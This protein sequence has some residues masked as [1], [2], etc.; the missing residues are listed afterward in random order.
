MGYTL[1]GRTL[2]AAAI[3][4]ALTA[5]GGGGGD[6]SPSNGGGTVS[7]VATVSVSGVASKG[8]LAYAKVT[9]YAVKSDGTAD[10]ANVLGSAITDA[11]GAYTISGLAPSVPVVLKVTPLPA[12]GGRP[13]TSMRDEVTHQALSVPVDS[14]FELSAVTVLNASGSTS[15]QITPF[16]HMAAKLA[17]TQ[18][19]A[20]TG[21]V[22]IGDVIRAANNSVS[23]ALNIPILTE[24]PTFNANGTPTNAA[25][26][27]LA[28]VA[29]LARNDGTCG[30]EA[31]DLDK[32]KCAVNKLRDAVPDTA[33]AT[34][35]ALLAAPLVSALNTAQ[36][37]AANDAG[38]TNVADVSTGV[39]TAPV[40][41]SAQADAISRAKA[42]FQNIR[43]ALYGLGNQNDSQSLAARA[44]V[45]GNA[46]DAV[47][48]PAN[49]EGAMSVF[50]VLEG[51]DRAPQGTLSTTEWFDNTTDMVPGLYGGGCKVFP[52]DTFTAN[53]ATDGDMRSANYVGCRLL[54]GVEVRWDQP[55]QGGFNAT[56]QQY[57]IKVSRG[58]T[59]LNQ[60]ES[61]TY[62]VQTVLTTQVGVYNGQV[63]TPADSQPVVIP[64]LS[65][66][67][68]TVSRVSRGVDPQDASRQAYNDLTMTGSIAPSWKQVFWGRVQSTPIVVGSTTVSLSVGS[69]IVHVPTNLIQLNLNGGFQ[70]KTAA[71][72][73]LSSMA[74]KSGSYAKTRTGLN[75]YVNAPL[76][77]P[78]SV[79]H[80]EF[81]SSV[82]G[83]AVASGT[84]EVDQFVDMGLLG[85]DKRA[86]PNHGVFTGSLKESAQAA[87]LFSGTIAYTQWHSNG[88][89]AP[90]N[91][92]AYFDT[93]R[94]V[95][96]GTLISTG[97]NTVQ[98]SGLTAVTNAAGIGSLTGTYT[99]TGGASLY[100]DM[101]LGPVSESS[102]V[103]LSSPSAGVGVEVHGLADG[104]FAKSVPIL[105]D[106]TLVGLLNLNSGRVDYTDN[107]Y[108]QY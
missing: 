102:F 11:S 79:V 26:V 6:D 32:V 61:D 35:T 105:S 33:P 10:T 73:T 38:I 5:C 94:L 49:M 85:G 55:V 1:H 99:Q 59:A 58:T 63:F 4:V 54:F 108:E 39:T 46:F 57:T 93:R 41:G 97:T 72:A 96:D 3:L 67:T 17:Q 18:A 40:Q 68:A 13:A 2:L 12:E 19:A 91:R 82:L 27:K 45:V 77:A 22:S 50:K 7:P 37:V 78:E 15:A 70:L 88:N 8:L 36:T 23:T 44:K 75:G 16:T 92:S 20:A 104:R 9:A 48:S 51:M 42:L 103:K 47:T 53:Q 14:G 66:Q 100:L 89:L 60:G 21:G 65:W 43:T 95:L 28:A 64:G 101:T 86:I 56:A 81:E 34:G 76:V 25:A 84:L 71:G 31:A 98:L 83:G 74:L 29:V 87:P 30:A 24:V 107:T 80:L 90:A 62:S 106:N 52:N 69:E